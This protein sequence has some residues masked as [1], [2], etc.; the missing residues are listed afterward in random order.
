MSVARRQGVKVPTTVG[1]VTN[2]DASGRV[3]GKPTP[4]KP[5]VPDTRS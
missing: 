4:R 5:P 2:Y 3:R 1:Y